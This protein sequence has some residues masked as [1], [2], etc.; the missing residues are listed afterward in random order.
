MEAERP[1]LNAVSLESKFGQPITWA[2]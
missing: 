2:A 1:L